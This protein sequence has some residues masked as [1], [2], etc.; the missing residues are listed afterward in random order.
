MVLRR[1]DSMKTLTVQLPDALHAALTAAAS[2]RRQA[3]SA[4]VRRLIESNFS[5]GHTNGKSARGSIHD[6]LKKY[7]TAGPAGIKDLASN[8]AHLADYGR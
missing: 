3:K 5:T 1:A 2:Q 4:L 7:Q 8:P 6:R